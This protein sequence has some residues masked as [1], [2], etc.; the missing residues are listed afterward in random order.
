MNA[1][2]IASINVLNQ[3]V[4]LTGK[5]FG[6]FPAA[7]GEVEFVT[8]DFQCKATAEMIRI[9]PV[10]SEKKWMNAFFSAAGIPN[11]W[12]IGI[13]NAETFVDKIPAGSVVVLD[14]KVQPDGSLA[15]LAIAAPE[16]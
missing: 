3:P 2:L 14:P 15:F 4:S 11:C 9:L 6:A 16:A 7:N 1:E 10:F 13:E 12:V 5:M 8:F